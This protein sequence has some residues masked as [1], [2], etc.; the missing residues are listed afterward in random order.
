LKKSRTKRKSEN[1][2]KKGLFKEEKLFLTS[3]GSEGL[4]DTVITGET[5]GIK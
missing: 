4:K 1:R 2:D 3:S 5:S